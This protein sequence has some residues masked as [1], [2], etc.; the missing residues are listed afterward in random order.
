VGALRKS[1]LTPHCEA[2]DFLIALRTPLLG[3]A[4]VKALPISARNRWF[5]SISLQR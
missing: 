3:A 2:C 4:R 1:A 5:E